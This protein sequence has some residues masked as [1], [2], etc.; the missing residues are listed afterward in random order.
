MRRQQNMQNLHN[1]QQ[2]AYHA[3]QAQARYFLRIYF[4]NKD[5]TSHNMADSVK[6][7]KKDHKDA[8]F[9]SKAAEWAT[10]KWFASRLWLFTPRS[11][12]KFQKYSAKGGRLSAFQRIFRHIKRRGCSS[13]KNREKPASETTYVRN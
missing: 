8:E 12:H 4:I 5:R 2:S 10:T 7:S 1:Q 3:F 6:D 11:S 9:S 13:N